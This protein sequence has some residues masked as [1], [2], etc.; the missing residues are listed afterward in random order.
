MNKKTGTSSQSNPISS[1]RLTYILW[2]IPIVT[3][4]S[5][6]FVL[7]MM[8]NSPNVE[9][10]SSSTQNENPIEIHFSEN[11][12]ADYSKEYQTVQDEDITE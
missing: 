1:P 12:R 8:K 6:F 5:L 3:A 4:L 7:S 10:I 2:L 11:D 9:N